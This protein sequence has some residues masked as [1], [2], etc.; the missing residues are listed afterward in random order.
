[1]EDFSSLAILERYERPLQ[2]S[3]QERELLL[4]QWLSKFIREVSKLCALTSRIQIL[5]LFATIM[6]R[7]FLVI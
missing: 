3:R 1:M 5:N 2:F 4:V 6:Q 7:L